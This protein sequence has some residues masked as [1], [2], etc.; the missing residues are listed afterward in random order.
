MAAMG[1]LQTGFQEVVVKAEETVLIHHLQVLEAADGKDEHSRLPP[2]D[3]SSLEQSKE[4]EQ[5]K[6]SS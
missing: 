1:A 6:K 4:D 5:N 2:S 3:L